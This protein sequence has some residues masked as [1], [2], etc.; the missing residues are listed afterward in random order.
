MSDII[1]KFNNILKDKKIDI[2]NIIDNSN[3]Q[4]VENTEFSKNNFD[5]DITTLLK[6]KNIF[7][8]ANNNN[9]PRNRLLFSLKP[10]LKDNK[11]EKLDQYIK[12]ANILYVINILNETNKDDDVS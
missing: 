8:K 11:K 2:N 4:N 10:F 12:I 3:S 5:F 7:D 6:F 9:N 1:N